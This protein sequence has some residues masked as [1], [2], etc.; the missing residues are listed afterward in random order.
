MC[1]FRNNNGFVVM[2]SE[3]ISV[4]CSRFFSNFFGDK[5]VVW[6]YKMKFT[7]CWYLKAQS[8]YFL[9][10]KLPHLLLS[11]AVEAGGQFSFMD[12]HRHSGNNVLLMLTTKLGFIWEKML[13]V[14]DITTQCN[15]VC[16]SSTRSLQCPLHTG[17]QIG[18]NKSVAASLGH[19]WERQQSLLRECV[20]VCL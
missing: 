11:L 12:G 4:K 8:I 2:F 6:F 15:G 5:M 1:N 7:L 3:I 10:N 20:C 17:R 9:P 18:S 14:N 19:Q 13:K 16:V